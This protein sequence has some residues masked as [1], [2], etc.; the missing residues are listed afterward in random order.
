MGIIAPGDLRNCLVALA[1]KESV[2][3]QLFQY[4]FGGEGSWQ[5]TALAISSWLP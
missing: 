1:D 4:R 2:L 3:E 5:D